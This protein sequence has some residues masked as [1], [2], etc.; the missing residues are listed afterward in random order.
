MEIGNCGL[1]P[2]LRCGD[3]SNQPQ[4]VHPAHAIPSVPCPWYCSTLSITPNLS[5]VFYSALY[6]PHRSRYHPKFCF[7]SKALPLPFPPSC[8]PNP[9]HSG[10]FQRVVEPGQDTLFPL[11]TMSSVCLGNLVAPSPSCPCKAVRNVLFFNIPSVFLPALG[12]P[13]TS[14]LITCHLFIW[15]W[16]PSSNLS[17]CSSLRGHNSLVKHLLPVCMGYAAPAWGLGA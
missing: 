9:T 7:L 6:N 12:A 4:A 14:A 13:I 8:P 17:P 2:L 3:L 1:L 16:S 5:I 11:M 15:S 10:S